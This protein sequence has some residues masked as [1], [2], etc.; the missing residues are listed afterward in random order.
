MDSQTIHHEFTMNASKRARFGES[1]E[2]SFA[3]A[4]ATERA[5]PKMFLSH[6]ACAVTGGQRPGAA[7]FCNSL[8]GESLVNSW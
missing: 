1:K 8:I 2:Q 6:K 3:I 5:P 7:R 4:G